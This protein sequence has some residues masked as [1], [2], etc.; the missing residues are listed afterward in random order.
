MA[1]EK[2][3]KLIKSE[4]RL[5]PAMRLLKA[6]HSAG[7]PEELNPED[8]KKQRR[9][10][11]ILGNLSAPWQAWNGNPFPSEKFPLPGCAC[12]GPIK[13]NMRFFTVTAA[14]THQRQPGIFQGSG[15]QA[16]PGHRL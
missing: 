4:P 9:N 5:D 12:S 16:D 15:L 1:N 6:I 2:K 8:L 13:K 14:D 11:E 7:T 10:Q 3:W